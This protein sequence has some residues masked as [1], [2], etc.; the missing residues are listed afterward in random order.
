MLSPFFESLSCSH[1]KE[2]NIIIIIFCR[3]IVSAPKATAPGGEPRT[4]VV[5]TCPVN[6]GGCSG[7]PGQLFDQQREFAIVCI[8]FTKTYV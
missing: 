3:I 4:G 1:H 5:Y 8:T 7:L 2:F 6:P